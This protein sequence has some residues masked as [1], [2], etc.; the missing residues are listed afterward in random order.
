MEVYALLPP[1]D[2]GSQLMTLLLA[3]S[4][5]QTAINAYCSGASGP[6][7]LQ[8]I[9]ASPLA[10]AKLAA[11]ASA[12]TAII[13][14][15]DALSAVVAGSTSLA[16]IIGNST[17]LSVFVA[18]ATAMAAIIG[19]ASALSTVVA[20][21]TAMAAVAGSSTAMAAM[22]GSSTAMT[23]VVNS[24]TAM[25]AV[26]ASSTA[27]TTIAANQAALDAV[28]ANGTAKTA[29]FGSAYM[30]GTPTMTSNTAPSG[31]CSSSSA[32]GVEPP[33]NAFAKSW[34]QTNGVGCF[35]AATGTSGEWLAYEFPSAKRV[36]RIKYWANNDAT[37][38]WIT[39]C[40]VQYYNGATWV[41]AYTA[42][43]MANAGQY[44]WD[45]ANTVAA[46]KWRILTTSNA[47]ANWWRVSEV[48]FIGV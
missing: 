7:A 39:S 23:A 10:M 43:G 36:M 24:S 22:A 14:S 15:S 12:V 25:A 1:F 29:Y 48:D 40:K 33:W 32:Q 19:N 11:S 46:T 4:P 18:S 5:N 35:G 6:L 2:A 16:A 21:A 9:T 34:A 38:H 27:M 28:F 8:T 20:S 30:A 42:T 47:S 37:N 41:D 3:S 44:T 31:T 45:I 26:A 17:A 13:G